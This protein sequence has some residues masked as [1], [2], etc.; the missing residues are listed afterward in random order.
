MKCPICNAKMEKGYVHYER[1]LEWVKKKRMFAVSPLEGELCIKNWN[2]F[3]YAYLDA[4]ICKSCE[5]II[6][7]YSDTDDNI[8]VVIN[9]PNAL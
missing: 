7:D 9:D 6:M 2:P 4:Y 1:M 5:K 3:K 8:E